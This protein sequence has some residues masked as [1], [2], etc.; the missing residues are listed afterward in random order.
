[1]RHPVRSRRGA[2]MP[3]A[4]DQHSGDLERRRDVDGLGESDGSN[5]RGAL[6]SFVGDDDRGNSEMGLVQVGVNRRK[7]AERLD[8]RAIDICGAVF[9][10]GIDDGIAGPGEDDLFR[11]PLPREAVGG[12]HER[13]AMRLADRLQF[14]EGAVCDFVRIEAQGLAFGKVAV[15]E[16]LA[17][18]I[19]GQGLGRDRGSEAL[20]KG[21]ADGAAD[22]DRGGNA[23]CH[24]GALSAV[25]RGRPRKAAHPRGR[26]VQR[27]AFRPCRS[28]RNRPT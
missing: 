20:P 7:T 23:V 18:P 2:H 27:A 17:V 9:A 4:E 6:P 5:D 3:R 26:A 1:M 28:L 14:L 16:R 13:H 24:V 10:A 21:Q 12:A 22:R 8:L 25:L 15:V 11:A 19:G